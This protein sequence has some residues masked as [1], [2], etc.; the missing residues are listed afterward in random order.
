MS[1]KVVFEKYPEH[2]VVLPRLE[3]TQ[4]MY[5]ADGTE[6][7]RLDNRLITRRRERERERIARGTYDLPR[8]RK[9]RLARN[10][11]TRHLPAISRGKRK[12]EGRKWPTV[13][14]LERGLESP[15]LELNHRMSRIIV[16]LPLL[17]PPL[18]SVLRRLS[19]R[20][21]QRISGRLAHTASL[22]SLFPL[23]ILRK[24]GGSSQ[25]RIRIS[26]GASSAGDEVPGKRDIIPRSIRH[27]TLMSSGA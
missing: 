3:H 21:R 20:A 24:P 13:A 8:C 16:F 11:G 19:W 9:S 6:T 10:F 5:T 17:T 7:W 18:L 1:F 22:A 26:L 12:G 14:H 15:F 27:S 25:E 2:Q 23:G 4:S